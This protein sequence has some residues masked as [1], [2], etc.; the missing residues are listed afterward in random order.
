MSTA[1]VISPTV[2]DKSQEQP[3]RISIEKFLEKYRKG[4]EVS[5]TSGTTASSK[6][7]SL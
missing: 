1:T 4:K 2:F 5:N 6:K 3:P 7:Q